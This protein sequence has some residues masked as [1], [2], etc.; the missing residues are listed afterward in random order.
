MYVVKIVYYSTKHTETIQQML[1]FPLL[2]NIN[3][4]L[5]ATKFLEFLESYLF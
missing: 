3:W 1:V 4:F 2:L 5:N